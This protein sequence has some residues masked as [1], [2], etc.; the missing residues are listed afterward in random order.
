MQNA[1]KEVKKRLIQLVIKNGYKKKNAYKG[2]LKSC[3]K[4]FFIV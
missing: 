2:C 1:P 4:R 3:Y